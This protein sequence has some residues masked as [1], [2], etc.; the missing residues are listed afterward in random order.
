LTPL[1]RHRTFVALV[2]ATGVFM[3]DPGIRWS[4]IPRVLAAGAVV[5]LAAC[6]GRVAEVSPAEIP[7]LQERVAA[8]PGNG[9]VVLRLA[10]ALYSAGRCDTAVAVART[11][12]VLRAH[13]ALGPL[14]VGQCLERAEQ[15]EAAVDVYAGFLAAQGEE[16]RGASAVQARRLLAQRGRAT[17]QARQALAREGELAQVAGDASVVAVLPLLVI[18]DSSFQPLGRGLAQ[19]LTS[20]LALLE[21]FRM[22]ERLQ[23]GALLEEL[24]L[25]QSTRM[26][27]AT[28]ARVGYLVQAGRL[29]Q[30]LTQIEDEQ[31]VQ[32]EASVVLANGEVT[33]PEQVRG[34]FRDLLQMEKELVVGIASRLGYQLSEA[35]RRAILENGTQD[36]VA[37]LAY[38]RGLVAEDVGDFS[39]AALHFGAAPAA[40]QAQ[41]GQITQVAQE[42]PEPPAAPEVVADAAL[43][44]GLTDLEG[45][46]SERASTG[47]ASTTGSQAS[48]TSAA[49][50]PPP[51][52]TPPTTV[53]GTIRIIFRLP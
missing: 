50:P 47:T 33:A 17:Q 20:D 39:A 27:P 9:E 11:G 1:N 23:L 41:A 51:P 16:A 53:T 15:Y 43:D 2:R 21:R 31:D 7:A 37:F 6:G 5:L 25:G 29:V 10:A 38:S 30:G 36:L 14:I 40:Q 18:G 44:A 24:E 49:A 28:V 48:S 26:D 13:D 32:L 12:M 8:E 22:V 3:P 4:S 52:V 35:E 42:A 46:T 34:R 45:T 19:M